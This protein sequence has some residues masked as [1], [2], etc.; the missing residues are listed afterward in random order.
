MA[1]DDRN[2]EPLTVVGC[3]SIVIGLAAPVIGRFL[4]W[5]WSGLL[6]IPLILVCVVLW[7]ILRHGDSDN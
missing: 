5:W 7:Y 6:L 3:L 4:G 2:S 1:F